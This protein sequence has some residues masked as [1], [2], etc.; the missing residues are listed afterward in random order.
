[1]SNYIDSKIIIKAKNKYNIRWVWWI[2]VHHK[3]SDENKPI[4]N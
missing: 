1:M 3:Y 2:L 4:K